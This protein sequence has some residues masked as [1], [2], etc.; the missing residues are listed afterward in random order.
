MTLV[1]LVS[2][3]LLSGPVLVLLALTALLIGPATAA[4]G[5][6]G[7]SPTST[8]SGA[9]NTNDPCSFASQT[10]SRDVTGKSITLITGDRIT[11]GREVEGQPQVVFHPA[12]RRRQGGSAF[13][14]S[15]TGP[16]WCPAMSHT[17]YPDVLAAEL[18]NVTA[19]AQMH[20]DDAHTDS[21]PLIIERGAG[22]TGSVT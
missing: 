15:T 18:F 19:L 1:S 8:P 10:G 12:T 22:A 5:G 14:G 2:K 6:G 11:L 13:D 16:T 3:R 20:Y 4:P 7:S 21:L 9:A 17:W